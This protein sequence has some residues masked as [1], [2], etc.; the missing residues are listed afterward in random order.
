[1]PLLPEDRFIQRQLLK[2]DWF[3]PFI[4]EAERGRPD[5]ACFY[6]PLFA[7]VYGNVPEP[8]IESQVPQ[9]KHPD[10][11]PPAGPEKL[12]VGA[13]NILRGD[14]SARLAPWLRG[15]TSEGPLQGGCPDIL[16]LNEVDW[17]CYRTRNENVAAL[18][19]KALGFHTA[20][21]AEFFYLYDR[22]DLL[23]WGGNAVLSRW[24]I[25]EAKVFF[26]PLHHDAY[27]GQKPRLGTRSAVACLLD[28]EGRPCVAVSAHLENRSSP[29]E[30]AEAFESLHVQLASWLLKLG[31]PSSTPIIIGGDLNTSTINLHEK[32]DLLPFL[33]DKESARERF[34]R[35]PSFEPLFA[36]AEACGYSWREANIV[37]KMSR[38]K[39]YPGGEELLLNLDWFL[40]RNLKAT[41]PAVSRAFDRSGCELSDHDLITVTI[42]LPSPRPQSAAEDENK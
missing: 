1:M 10:T 30:R 7:G 9:K 21:G 35:C 3:R 40:T 34:Y 20:W 14:N 17:G 2:P 22:R 4:E 11:A 31:A 33:Q 42:E 5:L 23:G 37:E 29:D 6:D 32:D 18:L 25:L 28:I 27:R 12:R 8:G 39:P 36:R 16:L 41:D 24:P 15:E 13:W 19:G 26:L 38:R